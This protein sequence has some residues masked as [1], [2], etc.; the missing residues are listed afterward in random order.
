[1]KKNFALFC[2]KNIHEW[3]RLASHFFFAYAGAVVTV[4]FGESPGAR[5]F[6]GIVAG[7]PSIAGAMRSRARA[8]SLAV[9]NDT[10]A[11]RRP[12]GG[13]FRDR[14]RDALAKST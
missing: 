13:Y 9:I 10:E 12:L 3:P 14:F 11:F 5:E 2:W 7:V 8:R 6:R 1:M 4:L